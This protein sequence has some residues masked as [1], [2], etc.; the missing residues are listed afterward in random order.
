LWGDDFRYP[1][2][3]VVSLLAGKNG[4]IRLEEWGR[5]IKGYSVFLIGYPEEKVE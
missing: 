1:S 5:N 3:E 4:A 2:L